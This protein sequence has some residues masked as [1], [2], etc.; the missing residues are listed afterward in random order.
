MNWTGGA[1]SRSR[2]A[3]S[4]VSLAV[5]QKTHFAKA[6][7]KLHNR[8]QSSPLDI[9]YFDFG[10]WK[11]ESGVHDDRRSYPVKQR[12]SNQSTLDQYENVRDVVKKLDS[13][14]PKN[15]GKDRK[16][17]PINDT[18]GPVLPSGISIPPISPIII[19]SLPPSST[20]PVQA[21]P[22]PGRT[23]KRLRTST[24]S[25]SDELDPLGVLDSVETKRRRLLQESDWVGVERQSRL[26]KPVK[27]K[28]TDAEDRDLIGRRRPLDGSAV[29]NRWNVQGQKP[30]KIPL[31]TS[32]SEDPRAL[33][34][35]LVDEYRSADGMS[36]RIGSTAADEIPNSDELLGCY[37]SPGP[38]QRS[39]HSV[40]AFDYDETVLA[41]KPQ[42]RRGEV[43]DPPAFR[44][45]FS[46]PF[47]NLFSSEEVEQSGIAQILQAAS[48][49]SDDNLSLVEDELQLPDHYHFPE[50]EPGFSLVF[51]QTPQPHGRAS[52]FDDASSP[53]VRDFA[54][55]EGRL[56]RA[57][58]EQP[59]RLGD[60]N[61]PEG[62]IPAYSSTSPL[63]VATSRCMQE[64]ENQTFGPG[65]RRL[66]AANMANKAATT[67]GQPT[68]NGIK[69]AERRGS[70]GDR[71]LRTSVQ[72][73]E[74]QD[75]KKVQ[76][77]EDEDEIWRNFIKLDGIGDLRPSP[78][79]PTNTS[80]PHG[81]TGKVS[82]HKKQVPNQASQP[83]NAEKAAPQSAQD[84]DELVWQKFIF[85]DSSPKNEYEW[86]IE[87]A[88][89]PDSPPN[90]NDNN[91]SST[92]DPARTEPS[93]VA[94][95]ATSPLRQNPH[96]PDEMLDDEDDDDNSTLVLSDTAQ[97]HPQLATPSSDELTWTPSRLTMAKIMFQK[98]PPY[99]G[100]RASEAREPVHL[101]GKVGWRLKD[102]KM[103]R[104][105]RRKNASLAEAVERAKEVLSWK[106]AGKKDKETEEEEDDIVDD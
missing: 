69:I 39:S 36:I 98:P 1:L 42:H 45:E 70:T 93:M 10:E 83:S 18:E 75:K 104:D 46:E 57:A 65:G 94:E 21:E 11:P 81:T 16:R 88:A 40:Q 24:S 19:S 13:L 54:L 15:G 79:Q 105:R 27:M 52:R 102:R 62:Q 90:N 32:Y 72:P 55:T 96:M 50:P 26:S 97:S 30:I 92:Y 47:D 87:E 78:K 89:S 4:K 51:E 61:V 2:N 20:S 6:R 9:Q 85:S 33:H 41:P 35:G 74:V 77:T 84:D 43:T 68:V 37:P 80:M 101:G 82:V 31:M 48:I 25:T 7:A 22:T 67:K 71:E 99:V 60:H 44:E 34:R 23:F 8:Q 76:P 59:A 100:Q 58:I 3:N 63:S 29:Q 12:V 28:F 86:T 14:R 17:S 38:V 106:D 103:K 56:P 49:A 95:A 91:R 66:F 5:K 53:I 73:D 64:L